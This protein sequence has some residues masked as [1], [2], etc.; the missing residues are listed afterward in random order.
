MPS[1]FFVSTF[2]ADGTPAHCKVQLSVSNDDRDQPK[3]LDLRSIQTNKYGLGKV[4]ELPIPKLGDSDSLVVEVRDPK[5]LAG[6]DTERIYGGD[7]DSGIVEVTTSHAINKTGDPIEVT[8]RSTRPNLRLVVQAIREG[9]VRRASKPTCETGTDSLRSPMIP[10]LRMRLG[11]SPSPWRRNGAR[12]S[13]SK[14][15]APFCTRRIANS[16]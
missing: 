13:S 6:T 12:R 11:F 9:V 14:V 5:G 16:I 1:T 8:L 10:A 4:S 3:K 15:S 7:E 2:Y